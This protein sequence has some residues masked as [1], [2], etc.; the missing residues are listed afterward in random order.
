MIGKL[1]Q[2]LSKY[3]FL[4]RSKTNTLNL[5]NKIQINWGKVRLAGSCVLDIGEKAIIRGSLSLQKKGA[6][7]SISDHVFIGANSTIVATERVSVGSHVLV[8]HDCYITDTAGHSLNADERRNDI[9]NRWKGFK[10]WSVVESDEIIIGDDAWIGPKVMILKGVKIGS[11]AVIAAG[12]V[13]TSDVPAFSLYGG[14]PA[15]EIKKLIR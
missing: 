15:K 1:K 5:P 4:Q 12:S 3:L 6:R 10:D 7:L 8:S 9:P 2:I 13:V 14:I 11:G